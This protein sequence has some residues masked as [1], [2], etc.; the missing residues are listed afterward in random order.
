MNFLKKPNLPEQPVKLVL[1]AQSMDEAIKNELYRHGV[2]A[3]YVYPNRFVDSPISDH[4]DIS[5]LHIGDNKLLCGEGSN[6]SFDGYPVETVKIAE[7]FGR[8]YPD[9]VLLN[10]AIIGKYAVCNK[11]YVSASLL[12]A[13]FTPIDT[14]QGYAK[15]STAI[16][17]ETAIITEDESIANAVRTV[18]IDALL[19]Q[20]GSVR[21]NGYNYGFIGGACGKISS[22]VLAFFGKIENHPDY[23]FIKAFCKNHGVDLLSLSNNELFDYGG[24]IPLA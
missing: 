17:S 15:C 12:D 13:H 20:K 11:K 10:C 18:G 7:K 4:P 16:V 8:R 1:A 23:H 22:N 14:R 19:I 21:L 2:S 5:F 24:L 9:D 6:A 3:V